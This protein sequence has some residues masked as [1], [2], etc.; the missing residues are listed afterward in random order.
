MNESGASSALPPCPSPANPIFWRKAFSFPVFL[1]ALLVAATFLAMRGNLDAVRSAESASS[2]QFFL[3][4]D[5]WWHIATGKQILATH[6]WPTSDTFSFTAAGTE[7][8]AYE[9]LGDV[10]VAAVDRAG[11][12]GALAALFLMLQAAIVLL[13]YV[14]AYLRCH[15]VRAAFVAAAVLL[16]L[17]MRATL[18]PQQFGY[19]YLLMTLICLERFR[20]GRTRAIWA[21][22]VVFALWVN[23]HGSFVLGLVALAVY[24]A[25]GLVEGQWGGIKALRW[26]NRERENLEVVSLVSVLALTLTPYGTRLTF[27]PFWLALSQRLLLEAITEWRP[28]VWSQW[29]GIVLLLLLLGFLM[30]QIFMKPAHRLEDIVLLLLAVYATAAHARF[31]L[32]LVP[33]FAPLLA[34]VL[35]GRLPAHRGDGERHVLNAALMLGIAAGIL[36]FMPSSRELQ[37]AIAHRLPQGAVL[38]MR[39]HTV[40]A[41]M[42]NDHDWGGYLIESLGPEQKVF[43]DGRNDIY[44]YSGVFADYLRI[45]APS[46]QAMLLLKRYNVQS[47]L[48]QRD[49]ALAGLLGTQLDWE[50]V[51]SDTLSVLYVRA[52]GGPYR[53][54]CDRGRLYSAFW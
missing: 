50:S 7:W 8:L 33:V 47:C 14:Y 46:P 3:E 16:P 11:G 17:A 6:T 5:L 30:A 41:P 34:T 44:E 28:F 45:T 49:S 27:Y 22:P 39:A 42:F 48:L 4:G 32:F 1:G 53:L 40:P 23:T 24:A 18:R 13:I 10:I 26:T 9:W 21:L 51:Y 38:Y 29:F 52:R 25:C 15:N 19:I 2:S 43:I 36:V 31:L 54:H 12:L 20:Q 37:S 35:A